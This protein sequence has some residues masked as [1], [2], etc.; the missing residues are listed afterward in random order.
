MG[1]TVLRPRSKGMVERMNR[2]MNI[3]LLKDFSAK[4]TIRVTWMS[5]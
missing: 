3:H 1:T 5:Y 2:I 4:Q